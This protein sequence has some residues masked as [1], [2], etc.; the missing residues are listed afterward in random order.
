MAPQ[1]SK[2]PVQYGTTA[3]GNVPATGQGDGYCQ[4]PDL[5]EDVPAHCRVIGLDYV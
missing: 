2:K 3:D 1:H 4:Q 5:V